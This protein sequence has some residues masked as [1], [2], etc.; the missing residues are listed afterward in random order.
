MPFGTETS[1][2]KDHY[3]I[4][5][6][7]VE[8]CQ[9]KVFSNFRFQRLIRDRYRKQRHLKS[10]TRTCPNWCQRSVITQKFFK[11][12]ELENR[13]EM[14]ITIPTAAPALEETSK[15]PV[16]EF[17]SC[18]PNNGN[19]GLGIKYQAVA[20]TRLNGIPLFRVWEY[21]LAY[22]SLWNSKMFESR[23]ASL[24]MQY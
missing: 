1:G 12:Y 15:I 23:P 19:C 11:M 22:F 24:S 9:G 16:G 10:T 21:L 18:F 20:C 13:N 17:S 2:L 5:L 7:I 8:H 3:S 6:K 14:A 4:A